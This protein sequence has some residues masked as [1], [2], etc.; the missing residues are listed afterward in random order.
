MSFGWFYFYCTFN[1]GFGL[2][3]CIGEGCR[4][5]IIDFKINEIKLRMKNKK[6]NK[7]QQYI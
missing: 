4:L 1:S 7:E 2:W 3:L 5:V 6:R